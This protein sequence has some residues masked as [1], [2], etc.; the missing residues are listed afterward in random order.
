[1]AYIEMNNADAKSVGAAAGD[2]VEVFNDYGSTF[3][4]VYPKDD[5]K[6]GHTFMLFGYVKGI[7]GDVVTEWTDRN[8]VPDY[9]HTYADIRRVGTIE[10]YSRTVSLKNRSYSA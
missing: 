7:V 10:E 6:N 2:V 1:M 8:V 4:M 5:L 3:A 9:K